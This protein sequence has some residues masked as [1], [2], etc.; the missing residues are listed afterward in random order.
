[1]GSIL[2]ASVFWLLALA[3]VAFTLYRHAHII[4]WVSGVAFFIATVVW[5][6]VV[7]LTLMEVELKGQIKGIQDARKDW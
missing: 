5:L 1:M 3:N 6:G 2:L 7:E 4:S